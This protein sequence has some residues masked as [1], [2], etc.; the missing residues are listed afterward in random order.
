M[1]TKHYMLE[2]E[3][4]ENGISIIARPKGAERSN[5]WVREVAFMDFN[6]EAIHFYSKEMSFEMIQE[7]IRNIEELSS[8]HQLYLKHLN[9]ENNNDK[10]TH[11][12][13]WAVS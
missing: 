12:N 3:H 13:R 4:G 2:Y 1:A 5:Y 10:K 7:I 6:T 9:E 11:W 8:Q